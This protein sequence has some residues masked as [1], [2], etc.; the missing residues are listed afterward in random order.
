MNRYVALHLLF[1]W[2]F[3]AHCVSG[4]GTKEDVLLQKIRQ[5][6]YPNLIQRIKYPY[7]HW[8]YEVPRNKSGC[9]QELFQ[10]W[11]DL[12]NETKVAYLDSFGKVGA[13]ILTGN[14]VYLGY[15]DQCI[16]IGN[17]DYCR[18]PFDVVLTTNMTGS[19][20][21]PV[22]IPFEFGICFPSS[23]D[24]ED[25]YQLFFIDTGQEEYFNISYTDILGT[26]YVI[27]ATVLG[28]STGIQCPWRDLDWT[29]SSIIMLTICVLF[30]VLVIAGTL[31]DVLL[32][33][34]SD[35]LPKVN[36]HE[37][38]TADSE[39]Q[40]DKLVINEDEPLINT[41]HKLKTKRTMM[42]KLR[43]T[44]FLKDLILSFSLYKTIPVIM[45]TQQPA[46]AITNING[47]R[48]IGMFW[49]I[50]GHTFA[51]IL[52]FG[53]VANNKEAVETVPTHFLYQPMANAF[54][55]V[56]IFLC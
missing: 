46:N 41:P 25:F 50:L 23:C 28:D 19:F 35:I 12:D 30:V 13:G 53:V 52:N 54:F 39:V 5:D 55:S 7:S 38:N 14:V 45:A 15:Y 26:S 31:V 20:T 9:S 4:S 27:N 32:W 3:S 44:D 40:E 6:V 2:G 36:L 48:V 11:N 51:W 10:F 16:D 17:T 47:I 56:D 18:F 49:V 42:N 29:T 1:A 37:W 43:P 24:A 33:F 8:P 22:K 34:I 21:A